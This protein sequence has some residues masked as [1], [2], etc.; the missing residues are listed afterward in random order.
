MT[1]KVEIRVGQVY[2]LDSEE[3]KHCLVNYKAGSMS[4]RNLVILSVLVRS[5]QETMDFK[6]TAR[7]WAYILEGMNLISKD[8]FDNL[9][10]S[11]SKC[12]HLGYLPLDFVAEDSTRQSKFIEAPDSTKDEFIYEKLL[13][14]INSFIWYNISFWEDQEYYIEMLVEKLDL[15]SL[16]E[17][18]C[19]EYHLPLAS[20]RGWADIMQRAHMM[21]RFSAAQKNGLRPVLL[22]EG[23]FDPPGIIISE[24][25][26]KNLM[27][28]APS[29]G[30]FPTTSNLIIKRFGLNYNFIEQNNLS[31]TNNLKTSSGR[32]M[33]SP[34]HMYY[35]AWNV[36]DYIER[37]GERKCE[38][39]VLVTKPQAGRKLCHD[40]I[41]KYV[42]NDALATFKSKEKEKREEI[43]EKLKEIN[44][45]NIFD[46]SLEKLEIDDKLKNKKADDVI[47]ILKTYYWTD[48]WKNLP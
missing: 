46:D 35:N 23:D 31:W 44:F 13:S 42:G 18:I 14:I 32:D 5:I 34:N 26:R 19:R 25:F 36:K 30:W 24:T 21:E 37:Y 6:S 3:T 7:G 15:I 45:L 29:V 39:N 11:I 1:D 43:E 48:D 2:D 8:H 22:Y 28:L 38:A 9:V 20:T 17:P 33:A 12:R 16:N 4:K 10:D 41:K 47:K 40:A 27:D